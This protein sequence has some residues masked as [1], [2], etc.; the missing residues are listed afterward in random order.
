M[1]RRSIRPAPPAGGHRWRLDAACRTFDI[2]L[3]FAPDGERQQERDQRE[4]RAKRVCSGCPVRRQCLEYAITNPEKHGIYGGLNEDERAS[5]KRR[6][7]RRASSQAGVSDDKACKDCGETKPS[8]EYYKDSA[9]ADGLMGRCIP[10]YTERRR[11]GA[12]A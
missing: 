4:A 7:A 11:E 10:C 1:T 8:A 3:F 12:V 9:A 6:R 5:E 2:Y